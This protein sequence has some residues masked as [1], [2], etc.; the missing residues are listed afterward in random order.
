[1]NFDQANRQKEIEMAQTPLI[2]L[3]I[4]ASDKGT[5]DAERSS[6]MS[7]AGAY[8]AKKGAKLVCVAQNDMMPL[9]VIT[10]AR[11]AGGDVELIADQSYVL[12]PALKGIPVQRIG[13]NKARLERISVM[14]DCFVGLP[15]SLVSVTNLY[16]SIADAGLDKPVVLLNHRNAFEI[17][18]GFSVD[19][20]AHTNQKAYKNIQFA[21]NVEDMWNKISR[22]L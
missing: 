11:T 20:F 22:Q 19:V 6:I 5:G 8:L 16:F 18:R 15:G 17:V 3:A 14:A 9:P 4:F 10:S 7:Q 13:D 1:M 2:T 21:D 12:P